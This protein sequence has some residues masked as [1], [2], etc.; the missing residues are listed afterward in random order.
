MT[1]CY[2]CAVLGDKLQ[3]PKYSGGISH[4][5]KLDVLPPRPNVGQQ[6]RRRARHDRSNDGQLWQARLIAKVESQTAGLPNWARGD[7]IYFQVSFVNAEAASRLWEQ[8][9]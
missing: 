3:T 4:P 1:G 2:R 8:A 5:H 9:A 6:K 7:A